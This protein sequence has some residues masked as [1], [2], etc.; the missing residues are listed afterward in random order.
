MSTHI[1]VLRQEEGLLEGQHELG[2]SRA[3]RARKLL[4]GQLRPVATVLERALQEV[5]CAQAHRPGHS[6][7]QVPAVSTM[8]HSLPCGERVLGSK[9]PWKSSP[10]LS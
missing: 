10:V 5:H 6:A 8:I 3:A 9:R 4:P 1:A 2:T 7:V